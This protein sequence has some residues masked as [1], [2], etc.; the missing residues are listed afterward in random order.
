MEILGENMDQADQAPQMV[1]KFKPLRLWYSLLTFI[2]LCSP[3]TPDI[4]TILFLSHH[5]FSQKWDWRLLSP[6]PTDVVCGHQG[7][8]RWVMATKEEVR[9]VWDDC[10]TNRLFTF[11]DQ[12]FYVATSR[13][14]RRLDSVTRSPIYSH[15]SET[16]SGLSVIRAFE[17]QHRF[18]KHS[19]V[20]IDTNQKCVFSWITANRWGC[21]W[22]F[23]QICALGFCMFDVSYRKAGMTVMWK[24]LWPNTLIMYVREEC[25]SFGVRDWVPVPALPFTV[26]SKLSWPL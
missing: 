16:V 26:L 14:L 1:W 24:S 7:E 6:Q 10:V 8:E 11:G 13:Q 19:E 3:P 17:H 18:L 15:F 20:G 4:P 22:I 25:M 2:L 21:C 23:T 9:H 5:S 12:I